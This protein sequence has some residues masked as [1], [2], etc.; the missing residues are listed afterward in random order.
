MSFYGYSK[1]SFASFASFVF[2]WPFNWITI[3]SKQK[4]L[5]LSLTNS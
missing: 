3:D 4:K 1:K 5:I 2:F